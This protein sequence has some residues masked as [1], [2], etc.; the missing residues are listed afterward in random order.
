MKIKTINL[1]LNSEDVLQMARYFELYGNI[2]DFEKE[3]EPFYS[4]GRFYY[5][6]RKV[7]DDDEVD[8]DD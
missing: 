5:T 1:Q 3:G 8:D 7:I 4:M 6:L 2:T